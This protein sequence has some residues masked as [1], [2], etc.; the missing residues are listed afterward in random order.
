[1]PV[2]VLFGIRE[3]RQVANDRD[4]EVIGL[5]KYQSRRT[6][7]HNIMICGTTDQKLQEE[8]IEKVSEALKGIGNA[9]NLTIEVAHSRCLNVQREEKP[10]LLIMHDK[11]IDPF[12]LACALKGKIK[13]PMRSIKVEDY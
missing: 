4:I 9:R 5:K 1:M 13:L 11:L 12:A 8:L 10:Y 6:D 3:E 2:V 7:M